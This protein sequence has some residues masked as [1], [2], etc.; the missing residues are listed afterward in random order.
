MDEYSLARYWADYKAEVDANFRAQLAAID[1]DT[2]LNDKEKEEAKSLLGS[3]YMNYLNQ[4]LS[5]IYRATSGTIDSNELPNYSYYSRAYYDDVKSEQQA[6]AGATSA[7][8]GATI[9]GLNIIVPG[10]V[11]IDENGVYKDPRTGQEIDTATALYEI[12]NYFY[13]VDDGQLSEYQKQELDLARKRLALEEQGMEAT[14]AYQEA[15]IKMRGAELAATTKQRELD[16]ELERSRQLAEYRASPGDWI[17]AWEFEREPQE[18]AARQALTDWVNASTMAQN[19]PQYI[20]DMISQYPG[21]PQTGDPGMYSDVPGFASLG[22]AGNVLGIPG[23]TTLSEEAQRNLGLMLIAAAPG[24]TEEDLLARAEAAADYYEQ[25]HESGVEMLEGNIATAQAADKQG[26]PAPYGLEWVAKLIP[27]WNT[28]QEVPQGEQ[29][30]VASGQMWNQ[31]PW[32]QREMF[33][34]YLGSQ[35]H[36]GVPSLRDYEELLR[37]RLPQPTNVARTGAARQ[38]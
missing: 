29:A 22:Q 4:I 16:R 10:K 19:N 25:H 2:E 18:P 7:A 6:A 13:E 1:A 27:G 26:P 15:T 30:R 32:S 35:Y 14:R 24:E 33:G 8:Q 9:A 17:K 28:G 20:Q 34:G 3:S 11:G 5:M 21:L 37:Q 36:G 23:Q 12:E 38:V 31:I